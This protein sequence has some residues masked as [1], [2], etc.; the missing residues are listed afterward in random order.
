MCIRDSVTAS[1]VSVGRAWG[2]FLRIPVTAVKAKITGGTTPYTL[3]S[4]NSRESADFVRI[5]GD[6]ILFAPAANTNSILDYSVEDSANPTK[7]LAS[8]IINVTITNAVSSVNS[9]SN[10][11]EAGT[12]TIRFAGIPGYGYAVERSS[13]LANWNTV[14]PTNTPAGG[15]WI[16]TDGPDPAPP[17]PSYY[18]LRQ[19]N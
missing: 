17:N 9:I 18:R 10:N 16:F 19:N 5:S 4:V 7:A 3:L 11:V 14:W 13:D 6:Y 12:V 2:T 1:P 15:V 8:S